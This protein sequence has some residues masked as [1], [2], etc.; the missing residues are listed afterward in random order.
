MRTGAI[1]DIIAYFF[2]NFAWAGDIDRALCEFFK[3][4]SF[5]E[6]AI[7]AP[8]FGDFNS[9]SHR[10]FHEWFIYDFKLLSGRTPLC[11]WYEENPVGMMTS[12]MTLYADLLRDNEYGFF[13]VIFS[14]PGRVEVK[15]FG[16]GRHY[17]VREYSAA[18]FFRLNEAIVAR[19]GLVGD[20]YEF[21]GGMINGMDAEFSDKAGSIFARPQKPI[22]PK[23]IYHIWYATDRR[24]SE[25]GYKQELFGES[26]ISVVEAK[27]RMRK[28]MKVFD[29]LPFVSVDRVIKWIQNTS[30]DTILLP[31]SLLMGLA[32]DGTSDADIDELTQAVMNLNNAIRHEEKR[33]FTDAELSELENKPRFRNDILDPF[34][35]Q[36]VYS[37]G[38]EQMKKGNLKKALVLFDKVFIYLRDEQTTTRDVY[39][40][41]ANKGSS[42]IALGNISGRYF[43]ECALKL[44]PSYDFARETLRRHDRE[45]ARFG[46][47]K[48]KEDAMIGVLAPLLV[49]MAMRSKDVAKTMK[50]EDDPAHRYYVW[51]RQ[52]NIRFSKHNAL[53]T[54]L[55]KIKLSG[56][57]LVLTN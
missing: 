6:L 46:R 16:S 21:V 52:F 17:I 19:V 29:I 9:P 43:L 1:S 8:D 25:N 31:V 55:T 42:M 20:R 27:A 12:D 36:S 22:T 32:S 34:Q 51:L 57:K 7:Y 48:K 14:V 10:H 39:R 35:W 3:I 23:E 40:L 54:K 50:L 13:K 38:I 18:P 37:R 30:L 24:K 41:F 33:E 5:Q 56:R 2:Q 47:N 4:K 11:E 26:T 53:P 45:L 15:S 49:K 44:N 28:V